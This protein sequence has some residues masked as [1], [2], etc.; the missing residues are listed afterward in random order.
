MKNATGNLAVV[1]SIAAVGGI[2]WLFKRRSTSTGG[3]SVVALPG[4]LS[5]PLPV[6]SSDAAAKRIPIVAERFRRLWPQVTG[7]SGEMPPAAL[8]IALSH[9]WLEG[10]VSEPGGGGWWT[11]KTDKGQ[12]DMRGSGNLGARQCSS[13]NQDGA[14]YTCVPYG[15][16]RPAT[17]AE[18]AAGKP[19]QIKIPA[20]FRYYK[21]GKTPDGVE[22][23]AGDAAAWD[24]LHDITKVWPALEELKSGNVAAYATKLREKGYYQGFGATKAEQINGYGRAITSHLPAVAASLGHGRIAAIID[25]SFLSG[26]AYIAPSKVAE[27]VDIGGVGSTVLAAAKSPGGIFAAGILAGGAVTAIAAKIGKKDDLAAPTKDQPARTSTVP[28]R[29][30]ASTPVVVVRPDSPRRHTTVATM[31]PGVRMLRQGDSGPDVMAWQATLAVLGHSAGAV[32]GKFGPNTL[33]ATRAFQRAESIADDGI[34]GPDTVAHAA[35]RVA[36]RGVAGAD[37]A[38]RTSCYYCGGPYAVNRGPGRECIACKRPWFGPPGVSAAD[39]AP[40]PLS[41][42]TDPAAI[43]QVLHIAG[44]LPRARCLP[45]TGGQMI[46]YVEKPSGAARVEAAPADDS[47]VPEGVADKARAAEFYAAVKKVVATADVDDYVAAY[48]QRRLMPDPG[49]IAAVLYVPREYGGLFTK[50]E[51]AN[52]GV[53][54]V[55]KY[56]ADSW[57]RLDDTMAKDS[58]NAVIESLTHAWVMDRDGSVQWEYPVEW[59]DVSTFGLTMPKTARDDRMIRMMLAPVFDRARAPHRQTLH[60]GPSASGIVDWARRVWARTSLGSAVVAPHDGALP[61]VGWSGPMVDGILLDA[62]KSGKI[63]GL[64]WV[65]VEAPDLDLKFW[66]TAD[67]MMAPGPDGNL[68]RLGVSYNDTKEILRTLGQGHF[69][70]ATKKLV[71]AIYAAAPIKTAFH[72]LVQANDPDSGGIKM[73]SVEFAK[74]YNADI[75]AQIAAAKGQETSWA[76]GHDKYWILHPRMAETIKITRQP[77]AVNYGGHDAKGHPLQPASAMHDVLHSDYSQ[78]LRPVK[79]WGERISDGTPVNLLDWAE[80]NEGVPSQF[81]D[82]YRGGVANA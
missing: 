3:S 28:P 26:K 66:T 40:P 38:Q 39:H 10:G 20:S 48:P 32:D 43:A 35:A 60:V 57:K 12:G 81:T 76:A 11:D 75:D 22:R 37:D 36:S 23:S 21:A 7:E 80:Q 78:L 46:W 72:S 58:F 31:P 45:G 8:E 29:P 34:V 17:A 18:L 2:A 69:M 6:P 15:D 63:D 51:L 33:S 47:W 64:R 5:N 9:A 79:V 67:D 27:A 24:F 54:P 59:G 52:P 61:N 13:A 82:P 73:H 68:L 30:N 4:S 70:P 49:N 1:G 42:C 41:N 74:R 77:A 55:A 25:P 62:V 56:L 44:M 50:S 65:Q 19:A 16:S 71:D 14:Y 53:D